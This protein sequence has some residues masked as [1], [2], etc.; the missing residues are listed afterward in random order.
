MVTLLRKMQFGAA[1][2]GL[3]LSA[4][5][6]AR[7]DVVTEWNLHV[8]TSGGPQIQR[9][10]AMVHLAM[11]D[12]LN[13]TSPRYQPYLQLPAPAAGT[14]GEAAAAAAAHGVLLRLFPAQAAALAAQLNASLASIPN[15]AGK[16][17]GVLYGDGVANAIYQL[18]FN[19]N[20]LATG[21]VYVNGTTPG[22]YQLTTPGPPQ[23]VNTGA[24]T[25]VPFAMTSA[26]QFRPGPPPALTSVRYARDLNETKDYG[27]LFSSVRTTL[28]SETAQWMTEQSPFALNRVARAEVAFDG[29]DVLAHARLFALLNVAMADA[30]TAVFEAKYTYLFWRPVTA[31]RNAGADNNPRTTLDPGWSPFVAT[32]PHPEYPAAHGSVTTAGTRVLTRYFGP[33]H[34][35]DATAPAVPGVIRRYASFDAFATEAGEARIFGGMHYRT[36]IDAGMWQGKKVANW[37]LGHYLQPLAGDAD[38][39]FGGAEEE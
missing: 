28:Q 22:V 33:H 37:L 13:A 9:T 6:P 10:L 18:R 38:D 4:A 21:P 35:F 17:A 8:F 25:W 36:S 34:E 23:P 26:A 3:L 30:A 29:R 32:P 14:N 1:V 15:G 20:I 11:F 27:A 5:I 19:D 31:I 16:A 12:A 24:P 39:D 7:A 2:C